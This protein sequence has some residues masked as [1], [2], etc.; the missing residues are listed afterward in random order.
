MVQENNRRATDSGIHLKELIDVEEW[1]NLQDSLSVIAN[2]CLRLVDT[3]GVPI[4]KPSLEP[5]LCKELLKTPVLKNKVCEKC[6]PTFLGGDSAVDKN[7]GFTCM[8]DLKNFLI[9]LNFIDGKALGYIVFGPIILV[10]RKT[11]EEY[12]KE[13]EDLDVELDELWNALLEI[14]VMTYSRVQKIIELVKQVSEYVLRLAY[15]RNKLKEEIGKVSAASALKLGKLLDSFLNLAVRVSR[16]DT[17]SIM[18][19]NEDKEELTIRSSYG[20][21]DEIVKSA[22]VGLGTGISGIA[23]KENKAFL[24]G[25]SSPDKR[26]DIHLNR[27][28][29]ASSMVVPLKMS[30]TVLG[31]INLSSLKPSSVRFNAESVQTVNKLAELTLLSIS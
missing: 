10:M 19:L 9:P 23:A 1:Q 15:E 4:T 31:V 17:G 7:L 27:P 21:A 2:I 30:N 28:A 22:K 16:A 5:R 12:R 24:I 25:E 18:L 11:K 3:N 29:I 14:R 13:A 26:L 20:L 8:A 6:L